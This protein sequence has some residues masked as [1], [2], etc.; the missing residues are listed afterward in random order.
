[1]S[2]V[3]SGSVLFGAVLSTNFD[4]PC[5]LVS[6]CAVWYGYTYGYTLGHKCITWM[7]RWPSVMCVIAQEQSDLVLPGLS[8]LL[9]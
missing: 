7:T 2:S 1:M 5:C 9:R 8:R 3:H 6:S 4:R